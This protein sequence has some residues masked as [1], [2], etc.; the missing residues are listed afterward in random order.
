MSLVGCS[1]EELKEHLENQFTGRNDME[2]PPT[3]ILIIN[4][5]V[6]VSTSPI[7]ISNTN[8][9]IYTNLQPLWAM[10]NMIKGRR[11]I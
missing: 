11:K 7:Q 5:H 10:D 3:G 8:V 6:L 4:A 2:P 9:F 1:L